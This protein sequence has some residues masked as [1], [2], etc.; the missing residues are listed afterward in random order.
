[1]PQSPNDGPVR[2]RNRQGSDPAFDLFKTII[3]EQTVARAK[4][5]SRK[6]AKAASARLTSPSKQ[7]RAATSSAIGK[8]LTV[9]RLFTKPGVHPFETTA[10]IKRT[11]RISDEKG[12][13]MFEMTDAEVPA[14]WSQLATDI[15]VS[16]YFRKAGVPQIDADGQPILNPDGSPV[17]GPERSAKQTIGRLAGAWRHWGEHYGYFATKND[18]EIF[19]AELT[20]M[21]THQMCSP[22]SPQWFNTGLNWAY[23]ITGPAQ[24]HTYVEQATGKFMQSTD[25]YTRPQPHACFIQSVADDLVSPG[26]IMDLATREARIFKYGSGTGTNFSSLRAAGE[27]LSGGGKSS[28]LM[29]WLKIFDAAAGAIKSGGTT[30]RAAKMVILDMDHPDIETFITWKAREEDKAMA[31]IKAGYPSDFNGEAYQTVAGQ[32][33]NNSIRVSD[34]F[35]RA[36]ETDGEWALRWRTNP[37][38]VAKTVKAKDL[39]RTVAESAWRCADPG[40]QYDTAIN[41]WHTCPAS[42]RINGSN[43]CSEYMFLDDTACNLASLNLMKFYDEKRGKFQIDAFRHASR[44][45]TIVLE[46]SVAMAQ[47]PSPEIARRSWEFRTLGLGYAN[48][49]TLLM[50]MGIPYDSDQ[51]RTLAAAITAIMTGQSYATS[52]ELASNQGPFPGY[53][54][55]QE[56]MLRV[57]R[58]HRRV[59]Y[60]APD[61]EFESLHIIPPKIDQKLCPAD[62]LKASHEAWDQALA[63]GEKYGY[64]NAQTTLIA[65][66]GTIGL[67]MDCDTTGVE[68]DFALVKFKKLAGGGNFKIVNASVPKALAALGYTTDQIQKIIEYAIG[69]GSFDNAPAIN[70]ESLRAKGLTDEE[71]DTVNRDLPGIFDLRYAFNPLTVSE[72]TYERL[73]LTDKAKAGNFDFLRELGYTDA[74]IEEANKVISGRMTIEGAPEL[75]DE[76]LAVFDCANRCGRYGTRYLRYGA[77]LEMMAAVQ[78]FLSGSISKTVNMPNEATVEEVAHAYEEGW[79]LALKSVAL[80]RDGSKGS[81][82]LSTSVQE[83][84]GNSA[85]QVEKVIETKIEYRPFRRRL[86][87][88]RQSIT[89]KF[90]I[91]GHEGYITVGMYDDGMPG[92]L[93]IKMSKQG[94]ILAGLMDAFAISVSLALQ[95]GVPLNALVNKFSHVRFEPSGFTKNSQIPIAKSIVDYLFRWMAVKFLPRDEWMKVGI[96]VDDEPE[97]LTDQ[98]IEDL[99]PQTTTPAP[100][101]THEV[102]ETSQMTLTFDPNKQAKLAFDMAGDAPACV[103]CGGIMV[104]SGSCYK[105]LGCGGTSGCS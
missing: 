47:F 9:P 41:D 16:K 15:I 90:S 33:S 48:L 88:E 75:K 76:H 79:R 56:A 21:L 98:V 51:G 72:A 46:I 52:A 82:P 69:T 84:E 11:S 83:S 38:H 6:P 62:L 17:L 92:E 5:S 63:W 60:A 18:G 20:Y 29:S 99:G 74:E 45:W 80:Y 40:V 105:C 3:P 31:L 85:K 43:P 42:G 50:V 26:G 34:D 19:E 30:R 53:T 77:H 58:N 32:N 22:N 86:S 2:D 35:M 12:K 94:S 61:D 87:D 91:A 67:Q 100:V 49:G 101:T 1:M 7:S 65:P 102:D 54:K 37:D 64:R 27:P 70:R 66:T 36:T 39:W 71:I 13:V 78:P 14:D 89:H 8:G 73:G 104:R 93:F 81:Q 28:G 4:T 24:G 10:W 23:N 25:A 97:S 59:A 55:N 44:L 96:H 103:E 68:P 95:Y 57:M